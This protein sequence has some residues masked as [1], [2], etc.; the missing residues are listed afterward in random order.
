MDI[1]KKANSKIKPFMGMKTIIPNCL[2]LMVI[3]ALLL[4]NTDK[5][6]EYRGRKS[7][8]N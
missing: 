3:G 1:A 6:V 2:S 7:C 8:G 4:T 5:V